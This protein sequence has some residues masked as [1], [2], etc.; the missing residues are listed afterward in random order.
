[1]LRGQQSASAK[2]YLQVTFEKNKKKN[3]QKKNSTKLQYV[4][5]IN[6]LHLFNPN[7]CKYL[8]IFLQQ[9]IIFFCGKN[10]SQISNCISLLNASYHLVTEAYLC[11]DDDR[12]CSKSVY[13]KT[14]LEVEVLILKCTQSIKVK[15]FPLKDISSRMCCVHKNTETDW[16]SLLWVIETRDHMKSCFL[17]NITD[18]SGMI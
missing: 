17:N 9:L 8:L 5:S 3:Q 15:S 16:D 13:G 10:A 4:C 18:F 11:S 14:L 2:Q 7:S 12:M 1:M 6:P